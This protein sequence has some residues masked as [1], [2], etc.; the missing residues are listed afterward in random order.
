M[1]T[2]YTT[3]KGFIFNLDDFGKD[4]QYNR[5]VAWYNPFEGQ[6][7]ETFKQVIVAHTKRELREKMETHG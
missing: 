1:A 5:Y 3:I 7:G 6:L 4:S 2:T